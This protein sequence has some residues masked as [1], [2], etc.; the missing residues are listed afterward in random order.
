MSSRRIFN[1][2]VMTETLTGFQGRSSVR[3]FIASLDD[4][5]EAGDIPDICRV[6]IARYCLGRDTQ[7]ALNRLSKV[8][9]KHLKGPCVWTWT[10]L[11]LALIMI[12]GE[13]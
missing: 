13:H 12:Q 3:K 6:E 4:Y 2:D 5:F 10:N 1:S 7:L 9:E 8:L 11:K